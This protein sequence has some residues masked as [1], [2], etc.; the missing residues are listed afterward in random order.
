M[1]LLLLAGTLGAAS[2]SRPAEVIIVLSSDAAP[3]RTAEQALR[4]RCR[5]A[6]RDART[7]LLSHIA[8]DGLAP[9]GIVS[10]AT[11]VTVGTRAAVTM[12]ARRPEGS[13]LTYCMVSDP[14]GAGLTDADRVAGVTTT[15]PLADQ[16]ALIEEALPRVRSLGVLYRREENRHQQL[17]QDVKDHLPEGWQVRPVAIDDHESISAAVDKLFDTKVDL[18][19]T[20][21]D[22]SI[23]E[24]ATV[25]YLLLTSLRRKIPVFG[26]SPQFVRGGALLGIGIQPADQGDQAAELVL[27]GEIDTARAGPGQ[28]VAP[29]FQI[30][31]N[32]IVAEAMSIKLPKELIENADQVFERQ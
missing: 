21:P 1:A 23:Y 2:T 31:L 29:R 25:R 12:L 8:E 19:W 13:S 4:Q 5:R 26:Y 15:V 24:R 16:F 17:L 3:Y 28:P 32:Q 9:A 7:H 22:R 30:A 6:G 18:I 14:A 11:I 10:G 20:F 27:A